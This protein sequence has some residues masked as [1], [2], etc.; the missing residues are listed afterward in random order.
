MLILMDRQMGL[1]HVNDTKNAKEEAHTF[2]TI[3]DLLLK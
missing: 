3:L 1:F 2:W